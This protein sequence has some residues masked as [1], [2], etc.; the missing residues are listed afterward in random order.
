METPSEDPLLTGEYGARFVAGAQAQ[1]E[2]N[3]RLRRVVCAPKHFVRT[4][5]HAAN[6]SIDHSWPINKRLRALSLSDLNVKSTRLNGLML[7]EQLDYD[8]EGR[9]WWP[10]GE[11]LWPSGR[12]MEGE[13]RY[14]AKRESWGGPANQ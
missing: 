1:S 5:L 6:Q 8:L 9:K 12:E 10:A 7:P 13:G 4:K 3:G 14:L 2:E 11:E